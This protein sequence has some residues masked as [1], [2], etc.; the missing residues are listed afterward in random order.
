MTI[1]IIIPVY[2]TEA[3]LEKCLDS[4]FAQTFQDFE[5]IVV[6]DGSPDNSQA[7]IDRYREIYP[8]KL[9]ALQQKNA[10][11]AAARNHGLQIAR[12]EYIQFVDSDDYLHPEALETTYRIVREKQLDVL[13]YKAYQVRDEQLAIPF[14]LPFVCED[15]CRK[16]IITEVMAWNKLIRKNLLTDNN[17]FFNQGRIYEDL[18]LI[19]QLALYTDKIAFLEDRLYYYLIRSGSTMQQIRYNPKI[20]SIFPVMHA[21]KESFTGTKFAQELEFLFIAHLLHD[22]TLRFLPFPEGEESIRK[23]IQIMHESFPRWQKNKYYKT[24]DIKYKLV[25]MLIYYNQLRLLKRL[26]KG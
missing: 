13:C 19:P 15:P 10:G 17:L 2:N 25:C 20:T 23:I 22:A 21:L 26:L 18:E 5:V 11:Q 16:Y 14:E 6:N 8:D 4:I 1:S 24:L 7:I 9:V 3:Y 12:G